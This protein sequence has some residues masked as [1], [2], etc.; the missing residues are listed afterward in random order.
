MLECGSSDGG[1]NR[2]FSARKAKMERS[3]HPSLA[4]I[5]ASYDEIL[6][7]FQQGR[8]SAPESRRRILALVARDDNGVEWSIDPDSGRW[9]YRT[10]WGEFAHGEPPGFGM[11]QATAHD[12][13]A[14]SGRS[15]DD[16]VTMQEV[17]LDLLVSPAALAGS[18][19]S[20]S[21]VR[22]PKRSRRFGVR[23]FVGAALIGTALVALAILLLTR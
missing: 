7:E 14:G 22:S 9:R 20:A 4:R 17:D 12:L 15:P 6:L 21:P 8:L 1:A 19:M 18:T 10:K 11:V 5:A 13:G 3:L 2:C 16:R 23:Q